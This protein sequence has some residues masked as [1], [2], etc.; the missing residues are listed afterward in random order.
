MFLEE[1]GRIFLQVNFQG[2]QVLMK[3]LGR[4]L[5]YSQQ[6]FKFRVSFINTV[7]IMPHNWRERSLNIAVIF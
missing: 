6:I 4:I 5:I 7:V 3:E 2:T 1:P